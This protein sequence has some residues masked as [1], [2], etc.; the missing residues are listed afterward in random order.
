MAIG[1]FWFWPRLIGTY[2]NFCCGCIHFAAIITAFVVSTN[3]KGVA[4]E[5]NVAY[6]TYDGDKF[7]TSGAT[8]Q[9]DQNMMVAL[10]AVQLIFF[11]V[12]CFGCCLPLWT[13]P[14]ISAHEAFEK[15][16]KK[17]DKNNESSQQMVVVMPQ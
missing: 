14:K 9:S 2:C 13:T 17:K 6:N 1:G 10:A 3:P 4:C 8:Y 15:K 7:E 11:L 5:M 16:Q 12:Q